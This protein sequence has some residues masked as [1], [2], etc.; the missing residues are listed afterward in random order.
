MTSPCEE[1]IDYNFQNC[2]Y[3]KI[4]SKVGCQPYWLDYLKTSMVNCSEASQLDKFLVYIGELTTT[5]KEEE[6]TQKYN[7]LKPC[8]YM[9]YKVLILPY[10]HFCQVLVH[11]PHSRRLT[12]KA[13]KLFILSSLRFHCH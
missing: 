5:A 7:C 10:I 12:V 8:I 13:I 2:I 9:E 4:M 1:T 6:L 3:T 11:K